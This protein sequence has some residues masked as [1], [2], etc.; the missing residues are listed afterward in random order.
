[1]IADDEFLIR[2]FLRQALSQEGYEV[3]VVENGKK[4]IEAAKTQHFDFV[5]TDLVMPELDGWE[6]LEI[7][8]ETQPSPRVIIITA[9]GR[10]DTERMVKEKGAWAYLEKPYI[11][12]KII[13]ILKEARPG[14]S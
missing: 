10:E 5:I 9:H 6:V 3:T 4:A 14:L 7:L 2:W 12:E 8:Q 11:V 1:L 13:G